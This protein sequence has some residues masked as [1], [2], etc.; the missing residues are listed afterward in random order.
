MV[1]ENCGDALQSRR[2]GWV[3]MRSGHDGIGKCLVIN[4]S[5]DV[6]CKPKILC[7][8]MC[9]IATG[10]LSSVGEV[11]LGEFWMILKKLVLQVRQARSGLEEAALVPVT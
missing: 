3:T 1:F 9:S 4:W 6:C 8:D 2:S 5:A 10:K 11:S 7:M